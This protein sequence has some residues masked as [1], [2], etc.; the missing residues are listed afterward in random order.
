MGPRVTAVNRFAGTS[1]RSLMLVLL[2]RLMV[3]TQPLTSGGR[4]NSAFYIGR[5]MHGVRVQLLY[6]S[7]FS[8]AEAIPAE[9]DCSPLG[10]WVGAH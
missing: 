4:A 10:P 2:A 7:Y 1:K 6:W 9:V 8:N 5:L 3:G